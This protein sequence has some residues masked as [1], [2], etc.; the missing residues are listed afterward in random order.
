MNLL[1]NGDPQVQ[2]RGASFS[3]LSNGF[4]ADRWYF[5]QQGAPQNDITLG[6]GGA[7]P[8]AAGTIK[9]RRP[10]GSTAAGQISL[11]Q[12]LPTLESLKVGASCVFTAWMKV[13]ANFSPANVSL[14][15]VSSTG[16]DQISS[17]MGNWAGQTTPATASVTPNGSMLAYSVSASIPSGARQLA[18]LLL[19]NPQGT[20][21]SDDSIT[22]GG[23]D[24]RAGIVPP[25]AMEPQTYDEAFT[26]CAA[27]YEELGRKDGVEPVCL[28]EFILT[29]QDQSGMSWGQGYI[30]FMP[31]RYWKRATPVFNA[32]GYNFHFTPTNGQPI[33]PLTL[34]VPNPAHRSPTRQWFT[35]GWN[36]ASPPGYTPGMSMHFAV[37]SV[38]PA[39][40]PHFAID[41]DL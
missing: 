40:A 18:A 6:I 15:I 11:F 2:Q 29:P 32:G 16:D 8:G 12:S 4:T 39:T 21:G 41:G 13:G 19:W 35:A 24:L 37:D 23:F 28:A 31:K 10:A 14:L 20:A 1:T 36:G 27:F 9:V 30:H 17:S 5:T 33:Y 38:P 34:Q 3:N 26:K 7:A 25:V 22:F